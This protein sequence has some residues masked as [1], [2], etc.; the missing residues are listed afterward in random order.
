MLG[1]YNSHPETRITPETTGR[2]INNLYI[3]IY[4]YICVYIYIYTHTIKTYR[5]FRKSSNSKLKPHYILR[6]SPA[7]SL[8]QPGAGCR[9]RALGPAG[10]GVGLQW[11]F[12]GLCGRLRVQAPD[13]PRATSAHQH[14]NLHA[15]MILD[16]Y[17]HHPFKGQDFLTLMPGSK[18]KNKTFNPRTSSV[19]KLQ[20][21]Q[22][23]GPLPICDRSDANAFASPP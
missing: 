10:Q 18:A 4:I 6:C 13:F 2:L 16:A 20:P 15:W 17:L 7:R 23:P 11:E 3:Y 8:P 9:P 14:T 21:F 5:G 1:E 12:R 22:P 19:P